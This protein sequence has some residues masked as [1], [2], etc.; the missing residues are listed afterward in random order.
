MENK[1]YLPQAIHKLKPFAEFTYTNRD[2]STIEWIVLEGDAPTQA[3][4]NE[5]IEQ[6]KANEITEA[7]TKAQAKT[8]LLE[9]LGITAD[10]AKLLFS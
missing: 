8:E 5:A 3:E 2:Y 9:R 6:V 7:E 1:D 10:E 4:I